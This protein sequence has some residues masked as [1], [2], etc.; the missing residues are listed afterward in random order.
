MRE[1]KGKIIS[2]DGSVLEG[3]WEDDELVVSM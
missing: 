1:G 3:E 2:I